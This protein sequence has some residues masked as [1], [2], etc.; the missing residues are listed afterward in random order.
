MKKF[1]REKYHQIGRSLAV[2][3][4]TA[5]INAGSAKAA[6]ISLGGYTWD[7]A[8]AVVSG[9][10]VS[11]SN[12]FGFDANFLGNQPEVA[13]KTIGSVLGFNPGVSTSVNLGNSTNRGLIELNWGQ[14]K[15]LVNAA[16][17]DFVVYEN[18]SGGAPE[19]FAVAVRKVGQNSFSEFLYQFSNSF[20]VP[21][22]ATGFDLSD[23]GL[24]ENEEIDAIRIMNL[25]ASD[26]VS[27]ADGQGFLGGNFAPQTGLFGL[28][29]YTSDRFDAD[30]TYVVGLHSPKPVPEPS[31]ILALL[32]F[33][34]LGIT[35]RVVRK[36]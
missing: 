34:S 32:A 25:I 11:G 18:G 2:L 13:N 21:V 7:S 36:T 1:S 16:G 14:G 5:L 3:S 26:K 6:T 35:S 28:G 19:A 4:V 20:E 31:S 33:G 23:F 12:I 15:S 17:K 27:G 30:I 24:G 10:I 22:F 29:N 8:N 9:S